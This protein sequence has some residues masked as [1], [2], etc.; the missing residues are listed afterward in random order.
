V[1]QRRARRSEPEE[2]A[3]TFPDYTLSEATYSRADHAR[4]L[5]FTNTTLAELEDR[6]LSEDEFVAKQLTVAKMSPA[7]N[8]GV[9]H[10]IT[11]HPHGD[12]E[13]GQPVL[14]RNNT[15]GTMTVIGGA[16]GSMNY[17][18]LDPKRRITGD[19][20]KAR[21]KEAGAKPPPGSAGP[22][23]RSPRKS[24]SA[25]SRSSSQPG[26][27]QGNDGEGRRARSPTCT[28]SCTRSWPTRSAR[29][30]SRTA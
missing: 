8:T 26:A 15:D 13:K 1:G 27:G 17:M 16:G 3:K 9:E 2:L 19:D 20:T 22:S 28:S 18:R 23:R 14:V 21:D 10:W 4:P 5:T 11:V 12:E 24:A 29:S 25:R 30:G 6:L 7:A